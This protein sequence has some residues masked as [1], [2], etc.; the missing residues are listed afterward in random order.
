MKNIYMTGGSWG[1]IYQLGAVT[2]LR[3]LVTT[4]NPNL[5]GCSAGAVCWVLLLLYSDERILEIYH[6]LVSNVHTAVRK[7]PL[8]YETYNTTIQLMKLYE[9]I[10]HDHP[11]AYKIINKRVNMGITTQN[12]FVWHNTF[13]S[14]R[15]LFNTLFCSG[16]VPILAS[17]NA[18]L[19][20]IRCIDGAI[21][22]VNE[23]D[24]PDDC[25]VICPYEYRTR[26]KSQVF[27]NGNL[28]MIITAVPPPDALITYYYTMGA[29]DM[30]AF[31]STGKTSDPPAINTKPVYL[32]DPIWWIL[33]Y[34]QP[35]DTVNI[36]RM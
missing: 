27:L 19:N 31:L 13:N 7:S 21:G 29:R 12:G 33:R 6:M 30:H 1:I 32:Y 5:Y 28:P 34:L 8:S 36:L 24:V 23:L 9:L 15:E 14:N 25:L 17:Y 11:E 16:H 18:R 20:G 2:Q 3:E 4:T 26:K 22:I 10:D 35:D